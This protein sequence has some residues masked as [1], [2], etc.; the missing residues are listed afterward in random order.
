MVKTPEQYVESLR[1]GR[2]VYQDGELVKDVPTRYKEAVERSASEFWISTQPKYRELFNMVEDG[3]EVSF[4]FNV[5]TT[6]EHL[7]RRRQ[8]LTT[9]TSNRIGGSR[10]TG[11][12][13]LNGVAYACEKMD[14][15]MGTHYADNMKAYRAWCKK[16]DPSLCAAVS[17]PKGNRRLHA[18][19]P[20][21]AHK[22]FYVRVVDKNKEGITIVGCKLHISD[23]ILSNELIVLPSRNHN[24]TGKDYAV[25]CA[26]PCGAKGVKFLATAGSENGGHP[27]IIF[28]NVFVPWDRVFLCGEWQFSRVYATSFARYHRSDRRHLQARPIAACGRYCHVDG[29]I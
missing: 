24:E 28:D 27:M 9:L 7:Q 4:S 10:L 14:A 17:D 2:V 29:R 1:D 15:A 22:D 3:E 26:V 19:D 18:E 12:D 11:I 23:S 21:Q 6:G 13:S 5:P 8:I 16:N 25:S 20:R